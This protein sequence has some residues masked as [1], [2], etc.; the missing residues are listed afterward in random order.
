MIIRLSRIF[1]S[2]RLLSTEV[3][4]QISELID[5]YSVFTEAIIRA[6]R[7]NLTFKDNF[8][9]SE[10]T[11]NLR[12]NTEQIVETSGNVL[13]VFPIKVG[14]SQILEM[15]SSFG[16][17]INSAGRLV[18]KAKFDSAVAGQDYSVTLIVLYK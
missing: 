18:V 14:Q 3:G 4:Q 2:A 11:L 15:V 10:V 16:F 6:L 17:S 9:C 1:D 5:A 7:N 13:G 8:K 12:H